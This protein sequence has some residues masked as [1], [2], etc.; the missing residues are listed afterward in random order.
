MVLQPVRGG[1]AGTDTGFPTP[2]GG[3]QRHADV[4]A[5]RDAGHSRR[6]IQRQLGMT[7]R[8]VKQLADAAEPE[9]LFTGQRQNRPLVLD[10]YKPYLDDRWNEGFTKSGRPGRRAGRSRCTPERPWPS[11]GRRQGRADAGSD[12]GKRQAGQHPV[13]CRNSPAPRSRP[14]PR[15]RPRSPAAALPDA[16]GSGHGAKQRRAMPRSAARASRAALEKDG[17]LGVGNS[18]RISGQGMNERLLLLARHAKYC[19]AKLQ[20]AARREAVAAV[21]SLYLGVVAD[22]HP[23]LSRRAGR[24]SRVSTAR[25]VIAPQAM[26]QN[27][28]S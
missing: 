15:N 18:L 2:N 23:I 12:P 24:M 1:G 7:W 8:T 13:R 17:E 19:S 11:A 22:H 20:V 25:S 21:Q 28:F 16:R 14:H 3:A 5:L 6:S 9:D 4:H 27:P 10:D 26:S